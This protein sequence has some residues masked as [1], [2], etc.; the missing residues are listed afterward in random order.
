MAAIAQQGGALFP[1]ADDLCDRG[2][3]VVAVAVVAAVDELAPHLFAQG[4]VVGERQERIDAGAGVDDG[5]ALKIARLGRSAG[6]G[7]VG[8][9][10]AG[11][12]GLVRDDGPGVLV[13]DDLLAEAGEGIGQGG[14]D[15]AQLGLAGGVQIGTGADEAVA[16]ALGQALLL[17]AQAHGIGIV[18]DRLHALEQ[19]RIEVDLVEEGRQQ[20]RHLRVR[21]IIGLAADVAGHHAVDVD[22]LVQR[23]APQLHGDHGVGKCGGFGIVGDGG[24]IGARQIHGLD[25]RLAQLGRGDFVPR[26]HP[27]IRPGPGLQQ[28]RAR[29]LG[30][31]DSTGDARFFGQGRRA[32]GVGAGH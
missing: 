4:A 13:G 31:Q 12:A 28:L 25:H 16:A 10:Q 26:R 7:L 22:D 8:V 21:R 5:P 30:R 15:P 27:V 3:G 29:G 9:G 20:G 6:G 18:S 11:D 2:V 23:R 1:Q 17:G 14:V 32:G 19:R 24:H